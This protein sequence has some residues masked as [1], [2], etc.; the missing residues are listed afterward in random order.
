M[1]KARDAN[2][3]E[4]DRDDV[5]QQAGNQ[6][7]QYAGD[8]GN[9]RLDENEVDGHVGASSPLLRQRSFVSIVT[10]IG[11][12]AAIASTASF[13]PQAW[14]IIKSRK[15]GDISAGTYTLTVTGFS[16]WLAYGIILGQWPLIV[17][18]GICLLFS[19]FIL[20]MKLLPRRER[21]AV[22]DALD[23]DASKT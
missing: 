5:I 19:S 4:I 23:P 15:T 7:N 16:L 22:A 13:A 17:T 9:E 2:D 1:D 12:L 6:Q 3:N 21:N 18:N 10:L 8:E 14:K 20:M 11:S